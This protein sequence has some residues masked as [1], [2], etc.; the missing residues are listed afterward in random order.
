MRILYTKWPAFTCQVQGYPETGRPG[1]AEDKEV[2]TVE[3]LCRWTSL[4]PGMTFGSWVNGHLPSTEP[5]RSTHGIFVC[6]MAI[7]QSGNL[8]VHWCWI[9]PNAYKVMDVVQYNLNIPRRPTIK[10]D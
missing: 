8:Q 7:N 5:T 3:L 10:Y 6:D 9:P 1:D 2:R 4:P